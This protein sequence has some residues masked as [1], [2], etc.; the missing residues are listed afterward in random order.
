MISDDD[1]D[2]DDDDD[3]DDKI[4]KSLIKKDIESKSKDSLKW[5]K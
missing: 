4:T 2:D 3:N 1:D 5:K